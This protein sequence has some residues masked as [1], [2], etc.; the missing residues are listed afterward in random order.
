MGLAFHSDA[1][2]QQQEM[3]Q[4]LEA[5]PRQTVVRGSSSKRCMQAVAKGDLA[6]VRRIFR[7]RGQRVLGYHSSDGITPFLLACKRGHLDIIE[8]FLNNG[9][10]VNDKDI[11]PKRQG[12]AL[13][14]AAWGGSEAVIK[15]LMA[16]GASLDDVDV[17]GNTPL[18]Y[19][20]YGGHKH[21]VEMLLRM[22][23]S[24][25][26]RNNKN[27]TVILQAACGGHLHLVKWL[28]A[29]GFSL[30]ETDSDGNT[31]LLFAAWGGHRDLIK[32]L[33]GNGSVLDEKNHNG[34]S[35]FLSA[36]NGGRVD[37][38]EWLLRKGFD[39]A[40]TN[41]N[42]DTA[43]LLA[44]YGGHLRLVERLL[45][46]G[47]TLDERNGCGFTALL[48]AANGG[49]LEMAQ[50]L[51]DHGSSLDEADNDGY[52]SLIL[53][54]CGGSI[55]LVKFFLGRGASLQE[56][57]SNG[58][59]TLLLA[60]YCGHRDLVAW[61]LDNGSCITE[62]NNTGMGV[63]ISA[64][65][66][67]H[68]DVVELL[69]SRE[70]GVAMLEQADE[71]GYTPLLL[72]AQR[73]HL[74]VV[75]A[76]AAHGANL[77]ARTT[78]HDN[79][80]VALAMDFP[81]VQLYLRAIANLTPLQISCE[82]RMVDRVHAMLLEGADPHAH[83]LLDICEATFDYPGAMPPLDEL[84]QL[85]R[86]ASAPWSRFNSRLHGS[87]FRASMHQFMLVRQRL[88]AEAAT[89]TTAAGGKALP[90]LPS[91]IWMHV[92][93]FAQRSWFPEACCEITHVRSDDAYV[94]ELRRWR[95]KHVL[96][97]PPADPVSDSENGTDDEDWD[98]EMDCSAYE[99]PVFLEEAADD[100]QQQNSGANDC[101]HDLA[102]FEEAYARASSTGSTAAF[103]DVPTA[104]GA[105]SAASAAALGFALPLHLRITW[106]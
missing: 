80:A 30:T 12:N 78:R 55:D 70:D 27:H 98:D 13:H 67:G 52:T 74:S 47:A 29:E 88:D 65:N 81:E 33:L 60:A 64:S 14:Y 71:G 79:D 54:A 57:N 38:V 53:A 100:Q 96:R 42:G 101:N 39:L 3:E 21:I 8:F 75:Q 91:E 66:G 45:Q 18:L 15:A 26:E 34:H 49:Q 63:L 20:V 104:P 62:K 35:V 86:L 4:V 94:S 59:T 69:L 17:V 48:S 25:G 31:A 32:Y 82:L 22:G 6:T 56:R 50:W 61:L 19:A 58:D 84:T 73:G 83:R 43:L 87:Q 28:L 97:L 93:S 77:D 76:L 106:V 92:F 41:N 90:H 5:R 7:R 46:L 37:I 44:A 51:L 2:Q 36:A 23:R 85:V 10:T 105:A 16:A 9:A 40:E 24:L 1:V 99:W 72:A 68:L 89:K 103:S 11:D 95:R 102:D